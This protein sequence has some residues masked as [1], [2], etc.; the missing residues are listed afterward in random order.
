[1]YL[2]IDVS[3][4][5]RPK[6]AG[7]SIIPTADK[8]QFQHT[9]A[10]RRLGMIQGVRGIY[11]LFQHTAARRRLAKHIKTKRKLGWFQHTAARRRLEPGAGNAQYR[12]DVSTHS[13]P[14]AAGF[15]LHRV[16]IR[17]V[18]STHSRPKA[19]GP[20][21]VPTDTSGFRFNTQPPEG[22]WA[23]SSPAACA[24]RGFNT[25]PPEGGWF[26]TFRQSTFIISWFQHTAARR[27]LALVQSAMSFSDVFQHTA[28]RRR[29]AL[30]ANAALAVI[31]VS[32]HSRPK[33]AGPTIRTGYR[34][35]L[36]FNTQPPEGGWLSLQ[37][38]L[39]FV[40]VFQHTAARRRLGRRCLPLSTAIS[41]FQHTAARR[42]LGSRKMLTPLRSSFNT[43]PP[44]GGWQCQKK[45]PKHIQKFQHT[46]ARRRLDDCF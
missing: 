39:I 11:G 27:R 14:K 26:Q 9:A 10:R 34:R 4:H 16:I 7:A 21:P 22:G 44:E 24:C 12:F 3:T 36:G 6:A 31:G 25:Q 20:S 41:T 2:G 13:R 8:R 35:L 40:L 29:L 33:A 42:R 37:D 30:S 45:M 5:S 1:M 19:A 23:T 28:A 18:V 46:A 32:T 17:T 15:K 38:F 43:Q